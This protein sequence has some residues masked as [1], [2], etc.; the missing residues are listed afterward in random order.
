[1]VVMAL[2]NVTEINGQYSFAVGHTIVRSYLWIYAVSD[3][4]SAVLVTTVGKPLTI[5]RWRRPG[6]V[7]SLGGYGVLISVLVLDIGSD[8]IEPVICSPLL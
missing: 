3:L 8:N 2:I 4:L 6:A 5:R 1:M 7:V